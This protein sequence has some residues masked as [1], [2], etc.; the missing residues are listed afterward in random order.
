MAW[1][2][3]DKAGH[4]KLKYLFDLIL[5]ISLG[6][7][8]KHCIGAWGHGGLRAWHDHGHTYMHMR[9]TYGHECMVE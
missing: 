7:P 6:F 9:G 3:W 2:K 4:F 1:W 8:L 5:K